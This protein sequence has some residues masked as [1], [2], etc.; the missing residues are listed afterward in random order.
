MWSWLFSKIYV[1]CIKNLPIFFSSRMTPGCQIGGCRCEKLR[2]DG[3]NSNVYAQEQSTINYR[4]L[5]D[6]KLPKEKKMTEKTP[7]SQIQ[8]MY[9]EWAC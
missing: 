8:L 3:S 2:C 1:V 7:R 5:A 4:E 9:C 6:V